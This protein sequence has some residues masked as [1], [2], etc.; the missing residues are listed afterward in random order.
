MK[1]FLILGIVLLALNV[2]ADDAQKNNPPTPPPPAAPP[3]DIKKLS[4]ELGIK[5]E[6]FTECY[7]YVTPVKNS[8]PPS[9]AHKIANRQLLMSC[10][11]MENPDITDSKL[12]AAMI[13]YSQ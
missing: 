4:A 9:E 5:P 3:F 2:H 7:S 1:P 10:L 6:D 8:D 12:D 11:Q 13:K